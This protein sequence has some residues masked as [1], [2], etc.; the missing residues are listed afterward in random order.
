MSKPCVCVLFADGT[1]C[2][3]ETAHA[4]A[5]A[6]GEPETV[7]VNQLRSGAKRLA[8][9][10]IL[11]IPGGF[12]YGDDVASGVILA[13]ELTTSLASQLQTFVDRFDTLV[14]GIC[15]GFQVLVRSGLLPYRPDLG[16]RMSATLTTNDSGLFEC[17]WVPLAVEESCCIFTRGMAGQDISLMVAHG[18]GKFVTGDGCLDDLRANGCVAL[19]YGNNAYPDNPNG[20]C[21]RIAGICS[22]NGRIFG[23]MPHP[24]RFVRREQ[25][26]NWRRER[27]RQPDGLLFFV[28]AVHFASD[29]HN[30]TA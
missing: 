8:D 29:P 10:R 25:Y 3:A 14:F 17:R 23:L 2:D 30:F 5:L 27:G 6:G 22:F 7:H 9:Y 4:F 1:N 13:N 24:E 28:N 16:K 19:R 18:E 11:V 21:D 26:P 12:S 15:N 20:S